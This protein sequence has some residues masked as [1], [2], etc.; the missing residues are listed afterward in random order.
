MLCALL[1]AQCTRAAV[2]FVVVERVAV[3]RVAVTHDGC[4]VL[5]S[6]QRTLVSAFAEQLVVLLFAVF[7]ETTA[8][9]NAW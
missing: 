7:L 3:Q 5:L 1:G 8:M 9:P 6:A 4:I 2:Q